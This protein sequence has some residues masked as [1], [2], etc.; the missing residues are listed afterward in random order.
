MRSNSELLPLHEKLY[1][2]CFA[3]NNVLDSL[4]SET[5]IFF[6][7]TRKPICEYTDNKRDNLNWMS[8]KPIIESMCNVKYLF[9][10][11]NNHDI[12]E[13]SISISVF[14]NILIEDHYLEFLIASPM[15]GIKL[16][17]GEIVWSVNLLDKREVIRLQQTI[18]QYENTVVAFG[19]FGGYYEDLIDKEKYYLCYGEDKLTYFGNL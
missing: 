1:K 2:I 10:N 9:V 4:N 14:T 13:R 15:T 18:S 8:M 3:I 5:V 12:D 19:N 11:K 17:T 16:R 7:E 6:S